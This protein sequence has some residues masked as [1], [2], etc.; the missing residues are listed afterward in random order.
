MSD[1]KKEYKMVTVYDK[2]TRQIITRIFTND[3]D[4]LFQRVNESL[5][6]YQQYFKWKEIPD[7]DIVVE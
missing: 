6:G 1:K 3:L 4:N 5:K 7:V 2:E